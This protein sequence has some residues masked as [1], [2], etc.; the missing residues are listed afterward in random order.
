VESESGTGGLTVVE[1]PGF[2]PSWRPVAPACNGQLD[3]CRAETAADWA[4]LSPPALLEPGERTGRHRLGAGELLAGAAGRSEISM[5]DFAVALLDE[6]ER[7]RHRR[8]RFT[9]GY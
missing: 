7:P 4:C 5:E 1:T 6:A 2:P 9:V 8:V 3:V